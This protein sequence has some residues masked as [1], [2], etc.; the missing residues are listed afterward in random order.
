MCIY[1]RYSLIMVVY[2]GHYR[3]IIA[4]KLGSD[5]LSSKR[6][7]CHILGGRGH[8]FS[9]GARWIF[10]GWWWVMVGLFWVVVGG[11]RFILGIGRW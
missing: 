11:G 3:V 1:D 6:S 5:S 8:I 4:R 10:F 7:D 9:G 2:V